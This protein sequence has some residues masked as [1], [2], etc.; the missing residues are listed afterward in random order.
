VRVAA[1]VVILLLVGCAPTPTYEQLSDEAEITGDN[2]KVEK[3]EATAYKAE[4][5]YLNRSR[6]D[7]AP[8]LMWFCDSMF[9]ERKPDPTWNI[10]EL[11][12]AYK[13]DHRSCGC[14]NK[15]IQLQEINRAMGQY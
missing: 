13:R 4:Q 9:R 10:D 6:C 2:T 11:V 8:G 1:L 5:H 14:T 15:D 12:K 7:A 3:F